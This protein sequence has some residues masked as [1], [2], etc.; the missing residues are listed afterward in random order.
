MMLRT[1]LHNLPEP[2]K[3]PLRAVV[4]GVGAAPM[5]QVVKELR[6]RGV[7]LGE[8]R[9]LE[10]FGGEG[11]L[12]VKDYAPYVASLEI[13]EY[14]P[15]LE[16]R[17][18][19]N[20]PAATVKIVDS[21]QEIKRATNKYDLI[22]V[23]NP[24]SIHQGHCEHFDILDDLFRVA[25]SP[26]VIVLQTIPTG[27]DELR[28]TYPYILNDEQLE[29]RRAFYRTDR[30]DAVS[31][32]TMAAVYTDIVASHGWT[33]EWHFFQKRHYTFYLLALKIRRTG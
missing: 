12:H 20:F 18:R 33:V 3:A 9:A 15:R 19:A 23:D 2:A 4:R 25:N 27:S 10:V 7:A 5:R 8:C 6:R 13:W 22:V 21:Y 28:K 24:G 31:L 1:L 29:I 17:L 26:A 16:P 32:E 30:P 14:N 11:S